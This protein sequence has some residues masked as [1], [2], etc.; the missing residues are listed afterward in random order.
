MIRE[1][2]YTREEA[3]EVVNEIVRDYPGAEIEERETL[4]L[5]FPMPLGTLAVS[6][7][8]FRWVSGDVCAFFIVDKAGNDVYAI[9]YS[10]DD[11][12]N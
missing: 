1:S 9:A 2:A 4:S 12:I 10:C 5:Y 11:E 8:F 6:A 3:W 7:D